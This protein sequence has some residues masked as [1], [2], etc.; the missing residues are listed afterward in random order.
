MA[1]HTTT[2]VDASATMEGAA[3]SAPGGGQGN[4]NRSDGF[5][6]RAE[7]SVTLQG[8]V[9][10][11]QWSPGVDS[12]PPSPGPLRTVSAPSRLRPMSGRLV[13]K[14]VDTAV[15]PRLARVYQRL[16][17]CGSNAG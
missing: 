10:N 15:S 8:N 3:P 1:R 17:G 14:V 4:M 6:P 5:L 16:C 12:L 9:A 7:E 11:I 2:S 13:N